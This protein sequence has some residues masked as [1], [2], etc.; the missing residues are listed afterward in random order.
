MDIL[1][2]VLSVIAIVI[3]IIAVVMLSRKKENT[4][5]SQD[6]VQRMLSDLRRDIKDDNQAQLSQ[7]RTELSRSNNDNTLTLSNILKG[8]MEESFSKQNELMRTM[9]ENMNT[10]LAQ[11]EK[12]LATFQTENT[13]SLENIRKSVETSLRDMREDN[14]KKLD[15]MRQTVDEKLQTELQKRMQESFKQVTELMERLQ[16]DIGSMQTLA[17][18]VGGLKRSLMNVKTRGM[19]GEFQ[20]EN[21]LRE[22]MPGRYEKNVHTN[23]DNTAAVVEFAVKIPTEDDGFIYLPIDS[24]F[25]QEKYQAILDAQ[26]SGDRAAVERAVALYTA[27]LKRCA[28]EISKYIAPPYTTDYAL[29]FLPTESMYADAVNHG[30]LDELWHRSKVYITGPSTVAALLGSMQ[31]SFNNLAIRKRANE[32]FLVLTEISTEFDKFAAS[33]ESMQKHLSQTDKDLTE[34][35]GTRTRQMQRKLRGLQRIAQSDED[36]LPVGE[37]D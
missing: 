19:M 26:D 30:M 2:I 9:Q 8:S 22:V 1:Q 20:L 16:K 3:G 28:D 5:V 17:S 12:R 11:F 35:I 23:P 4:G 25:P 34:L 7:L 24:K 33:L 27:E 13:Q 32:V 14:N 37:E 18:D 36:A 29:M 31:L 15:E 10:Q 21:I 6:E